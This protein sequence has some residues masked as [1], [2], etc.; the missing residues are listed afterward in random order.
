[1]HHT[2]TA[3]SP[4]RLPNGQ[5]GTTGRVAVSIAVALCVCLLLASCGDSG[6]VTPKA[7]DKTTSPVTGR[8]LVDG[9]PVEKLRVTCENAAEGNEPSLRSLGLTDAKGTVAF[10]TFRDSDGVPPGDYVLTFAWQDWDD[11]WNRHEGPDR[12]GG[13]YSDPEKS[14]YRLTVREG[15]TT[16]LGTIKLS[17]E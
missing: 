6:P 5:F 15:E 16:D 1:M 10:S 2:T 3:C 4:A 9:E 13:R 7:V 12:L 11:Y 8:I 17:T 14:E